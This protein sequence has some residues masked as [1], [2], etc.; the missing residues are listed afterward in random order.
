MSIITRGP[1]WVSLQEDH[2][3]YHYNKTTMSII[4]R[5]VTTMNIITRGATT[6]SIITRG[7]QWVSWQEDHNEYHYKRTTISIITRRATTMSIITRGPQWVSLQEERPRAVCPVSSCVNYVTIN[8]CLL[9]ASESPVEWH[10]TTSLLTTVVSE[11]VTCW[12]DTSSL[13]CQQLR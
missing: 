12:V 13:S 3:E 8:Y 4:T 9:W 11:R 6:I 2:N 10:L 5:G 1:Q 7:P